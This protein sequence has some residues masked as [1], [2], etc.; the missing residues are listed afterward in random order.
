M[1]TYAVI[2]IVAALVNVIGFIWL[3]IV[4]FQ[5]S[6]LW[7]ILVFLFS[8]F[9]AIIFAIMYWY[10]AKKPFLIYLLSSIVFFVG[11]FMFFSQPEVGGKFKEVYQKLESGE[12][13]PNEAVG[14]MGEEPSSPADETP[15]TPDGKVEPQP[16]ATDT[17]M[18]LETIEQTPSADAQA[19]T[20]PEEKTNPKETKPAEEETTR[21]PS[22]GT[23]K[24]DPLAAKK[25]KQ[26]S[27][28]IRVKPENIGSYTGRYFIITTT[29]GNQH[30]GLLNKV[31][32]STLF[33]SRKLYG[34]NFE[35]RVS[36]KKVK[37]VDML[38]KEYVK[39]FMER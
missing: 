4:A 3:L 16:G 11:L 29:D 37:H 25:T 23:I 17:E 36:R 26:V 32:K 20:P 31:T 22:P 21:F 9:T 1:G 14:L 12:I 34:G 13:E 30:R 7:G 2:A 10:E 27:P 8:P 28:T 19:A 38:K 39:E 18:Q 33:L 15:V 35:Y 5:R 6:V 24:P